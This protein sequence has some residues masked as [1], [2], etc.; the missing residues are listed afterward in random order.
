MSAEPI[1][2][3]LGQAYREAMRQ[4][5]TMSNLEVWYF[6]VDVAEVIAGLESQA[7]TTGSKTQAR[8]AAVATKAVEKARTKDSMKALDKLT[9]VVD[10]ELV[11]INDPPLL[12]P[13][14]DLFPEVESEQVIAMFRDILRRHGTV[15][16]RQGHAFRSAGQRELS[17]HR[18]S[19]IRVYPGGTSHVGP[20]A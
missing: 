9:H 15:A 5:A 6:H 2:R 8:M 20:D 11:I 19:Y 14:D 12:V 13:V 1:A 3:A 18:Y 17:P 16:P 4:M 10:G 7:A